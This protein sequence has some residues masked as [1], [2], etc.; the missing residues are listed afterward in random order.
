MS[1]GELELQYFSI[2]NPNKKLMILTQRDYRQQNFTAEDIEKIAALSEGRDIGGGGSGA[3]SSNGSTTEGKDG[4]GA[5]DEGGDQSQ[6][7]SGQNS[8]QNQQQNNN[9]GDQGANNKGDQNAQQQNNNAADDDEFETKDLESLGFS[10]LE[11]I[12][13]L[14]DNYAKAQKELEEVRAQLT[15][16]SEKAKL[17]LDFAN[18]HEGRELDEAKR[19]LDIVGLDL[20]KEADHSLRFR[21]FELKPE[22][23]G[24]SPESLRVLF[25]DEELKNFGDPTTEGG[26]TEVQKIRSQ[27]ATAAARESIQKIQDDY[28]KAA[29]SQGAKQPTAEELAAE[30]A[31]HTAFV[32]EQTQKFAGIQLKLAATL[33]DGKNYEGA[34]NFN[35]DPKTQLEAV[36]KALVDPAGWWEG[37]MQKSGALVN[38]KLDYVKMADLITRFEFNEELLN[39]SYT[40]GRNDQIAFNAKNHRNAKQ[41]DN[42]GGGGGDQGKGEKST[43]EHMVEGALNAIGAKQQ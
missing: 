1:N 23:K 16:K 39:Q 43:R 36:H 26:Q 17:L 41:V 7:N 13:E 2:A 18:S 5:D 19:Y 25:A 21:A 42:T 20:T 33:E 27:I 12:T 10:S 35:L 31:E 37:V 11:E 15:P 4:N 9:G 34:V 28:K 24:L 3:N 40:Q 14:R 30:L 22:N 32:K 38:G 8:D 6:N 29:G